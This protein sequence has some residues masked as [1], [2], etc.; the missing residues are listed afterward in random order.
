MFESKVNRNIIINVDFELFETSSY[1]Y[2]QSSYNM[3]KQKMKFKELC[4][5][6]DKVEKKTSLCCS[7]S[8]ATVQYN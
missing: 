8:T 3:L 2:M 5:N 1:M 4:Y 6:D 7:F